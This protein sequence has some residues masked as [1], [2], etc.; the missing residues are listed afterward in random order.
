MISLPI[1]GSTEKY[2]VNP[3]KIIALGLNYFDHIEESAKIAEQFAIGK[4]NSQSKIPKEPI[5]FPKTP[6]VLIGPEK[7]IVLPRI[8]YEY[9]F[10]SVRT[11]LEAELAIIIKNR[12][13]NVSEKEA[14]AHIYGYTAMNDVSQR[15]IQKSDKS[16][17]FRGKSF[18]TFGPIGPKIILHDDLMKIGDPQ[19]LSISSR[20]N[21]KIKQESNTKHMIFSI[22]QIVSFISRNF[23]LEAGDLILTG[24]PQG[25]SPINAGDIVEIEVEHIGI[26]RNPVEMEPPFH[27]S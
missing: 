2:N 18:D 5:L 9:N 3:S 27:S 16:G 17:W 8:S 14:F 25:V 20:V 23:T 4:Q 22:P 10:E 1:V 12:C 24:T 26:L 19:N 6:N 7:P 13:H 15:N 11:D 21:G